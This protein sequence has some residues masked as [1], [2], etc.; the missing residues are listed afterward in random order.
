MEVAHCGKLYWLAFLSM[1]RLQAIALHGESFFPVVEA[2]FLDV[3]LQTTSI[4]IFLHERIFNMGIHGY[5]VL[6]P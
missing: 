6:I 1:F 3:V 4:S 2:S 5:P